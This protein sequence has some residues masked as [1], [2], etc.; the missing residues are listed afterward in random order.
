ME[1]V[2]TQDERSE[3]WR[4]IVCIL[5]I[6]Y[7]TP[8]AAIPVWLISRWSNLTKWVVTII[9]IVAL[10]LLY[11][12]SY[13]GYKFSKFQ[14][15]YAPVLEV[16]QALDVYG[17]E[18]GSYPDKLDDLKPN[19]LKEIPNNSLEYEKTENGKSYSLKAVVQ[20]K[21]VQLGPVLKAK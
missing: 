17:I 11:W 8:V 14:N 18:K 1:E 5:C 2:I 15:A 4:D 9:S 3:S 16:Q 6:A 21:T 19:L 12:T 20:G 13:G 10:L 7:L